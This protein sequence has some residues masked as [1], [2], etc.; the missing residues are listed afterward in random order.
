MANRVV[1][2][3]AVGVDNPGVVSRLKGAASGALRIAEWLET[4]RPLGVEPIS[5]VLTDTGPDKVDFKVVRDAAKRLMDNHALDL[6]IVY[7][8]GHGFVRGGGSE[9]VLLSD[10]PAYQQAI[11]VL[12]TAK[13]AKRSGVPHVVVISD[14]CR[15]SADAFGAVGE[16][17][18][19][20]LLPVSQTPC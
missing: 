7:L 9:F 2:L 13:N 12:A 5:E 18:S 8:A 16:I 17:V 4:Q 1:G 20:G 14:A 11:D 10:F 3:V 15:S 19:I 6:L